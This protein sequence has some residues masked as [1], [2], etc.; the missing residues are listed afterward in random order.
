MKLFIKD[1]TAEMNKISELVSGEKNIPGILLAI[2]ETEMKI[3]Y[4]DGKKAYSGRID[5]EHEEGDINGEIVVDYNN[6]MGVINKCQPSGII[7]VDY[8]NMLFTEANVID[9]VAQQK[10]LMDNGTEEGEFRVLAE[11]RMK[12]SWNEVNSSL[13]TAIL[14]RMD[15][16]GI[17]N[18][19]VT[20]TWDIEELQEVFMKCSTEKSRIIYMSPSIQKA[21]VANLAHTTAVPISQMDVSPMDVEILADS[22]TKD[23]AT[24]EQIEEETEK[25][26]NRMKFPATISTTIAKQ[27]CGILSKIG[28]GVTVYTHAD[29]GYFNIFTEDEQ[30]GIW[31]AMSEGSKAQTSQFEKYSSIVYD[32]YQINFV[33]EFLVDAIKSAVSSSASEKLVF[34]FE[35]NEAGEIEIVLAVTNSNA[36]VNDVYK[37]VCDDVIDTIGDIESRQLKIALKVYEDMLSQLKTEMVGMDIKIM[38]DGSACIRLAEIDMEKNIE[39]YYEARERLGLNDI[40]PTPVE[41]KI[42]YRVK[43]LKTTQYTLVAK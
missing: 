4:A 11:K 2:D 5:I 19:D 12:L 37:V 21:F 38:S 8:I 1:I 27:V 16:D 18:A 42:G 31:F 34:S 35:K 39:M 3:R 13:R 24:K 17:F 20:D 40:E 36:S 43:T 6:L 32:S 10:C 29:K 25:L 15:Y 23:G 26:Y 7:V 22:M 9:I 33:R 14:G 41:E 30:T 28:K